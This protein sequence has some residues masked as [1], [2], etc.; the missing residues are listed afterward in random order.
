LESIVPAAGHPSSVSLVYERLRDEIVRGA[1]LPGAPLRLH[2]LATAYG[3]SMI[4]I[5]E[6]FR[7]L[8][9]EGF[10]RIVPNKGARVAELS[11]SEMQDVYRAR[12]LIEEDALRLAFPHITTETLE[13]ARWLSQEALRLRLANDPAAHELHREVHASLYQHANSPWLMRMINLMW[14]HA[15]RYR[16]IATEQMPPGI[17]SREHEEIIDSIA[18]GDLEG[19]VVHLR[20]HIQSSV[21]AVANAFMESTARDEEEPAPLT[22][23]GE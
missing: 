15:F 7:R 14:D 8:E 5:R 11:L 20:A 13:R 18:E 6:A 10:V 19:A 9:A 17:H 4:P 1:Q 23:A 21:D 3:V 2:D 12:W 16:L 22:F